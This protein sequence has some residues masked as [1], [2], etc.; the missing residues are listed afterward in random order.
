MSIH[1]SYFKRNNT[2]INNSFT[3][4][5][6]SPIT[7]LYFGSSTDF[8]SS[9]GFSRFIFDLDLT[10][11]IQKI[12]D[13]TIPQYGC[14]FSST[15][16]T[17]RMT[18]TSS[19]DNE[20]LNTS[21]SEGRKRATSFDLILFR[22]PKTSG[23]TG[24]PQTWDEGVGYDYYDIKKT[25]NSTNALLTPLVLPEDK[26]YS[27]RPSNWYQRNTLSG[28]SEYGIYSNKNNGNVNYNNLIIVDTQHFEF[29]N[30]NIEFDMTNEING[31]LTGSTTGVTGWGIAFVPELENLSGLTQN[32]SVGFF[33]RHTQTFYQPFLE[34]TYNDFVDDDRNSFYSNKVNKLY[35]YSY[36]N[37][38]LTSLDQYPQVEIRNHLDETVTTEVS[39]E[40]T[41]GIYQISF[42]ASSITTPCM[43][44]DEWSNLEYNNIPITIITNEL[45]VLPFK[46]YFTLG[47]ESKDPSIY[48]FD[49]YGIKQNEKIVNTDIR[50][51][52]V[53]IKKAYSTNEVLTP[54]TASYRVYVREGQTEVQ[55]QDWTRINRTSNEFFFMFDTR[56]K[57]PNEYFID[58]KVL[59][60]GQVD[61]Y[62]RTL[63]FQIVNQK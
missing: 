11:L 10:D 53:V 14:N 35:L 34:T 52:G 51:V 2:I 1:R 13:K 36:I 43:W 33:T 19:F 63:Q 44:T 42:S 23:T 41:T 6:K 60:S 62:K 28:W 56:D 48:G 21:T 46:N 15:T 58:I 40:V 54:V 7:E 5:G 38:E 3:N 31:I 22:I 16:H 57:L 39:C 45:V 8:Y 37:G 29:G 61:T 55:V 25:E 59:S 47:T 17:L 50:K 9:P 32:Y 27:N 12:S 20:L 18:N 30:E 26:S 24:T 49:F 4:T